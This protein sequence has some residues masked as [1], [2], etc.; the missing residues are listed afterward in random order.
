ME[1]RFFGERQ[2]PG[3]LF[4]VREGVEEP[5]AEFNGEIRRIF[6]GKG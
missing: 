3:L 4:F 5:L 1:H 2:K 6:E